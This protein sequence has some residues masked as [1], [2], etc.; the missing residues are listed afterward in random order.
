MGFSKWIG[1]NS[2]TILT[3]VGVGTSILAGVLFAH[4]GAKTALE[5]DD[6]RSRLPEDE[7]I[8]AK[9]KAK[10]AAKHFWPAV[11]V[12]G[13]SVAS[14]IGS[15]K[16]HS[17]RTT[18]AL[19]SASMATQALTDYRG[20][21]RKQLGD[22]AD[23]RVVDG[24]AKDKVS[25]IVD[26]N[27]GKL[28]AAV[29][30][31]CNGD[32]YCVDSLTGQAFWSSPEKLHKAENMFVKELNEDYS[33]TWEEWNNKLPLRPINDGVAEELEWTSDDNFALLFTSDL[34]NERPVLYIQYCSLPHS[35]RRMGDGY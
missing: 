28:P 11:A 19:A 10:I 31:K 5:I 2:T 18:A 24:V 33:A 4:A 8:S 32:V 3:V 26:D 34:V 7:D 29:N 9:E 14:V 12:E 1:K 6:R 27:D 20:Q 23:R 22:T 15:N 30:P 35:C 16:I 13:I 25:K 17:I 21:V